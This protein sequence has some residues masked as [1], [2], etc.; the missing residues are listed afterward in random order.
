MKYPITI[1]IP[2]T[3][4]RGATI[5]FKAAP[6]ENPMQN[7]I[8]AKRNATQRLMPRQAEKGHAANDIPPT[9]GIARTSAIGAT[10][11]KSKMHPKLMRALIYQGLLLSVNY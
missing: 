5:T 2:Q 4:T 6:N 7:S 8:N 11:K 1:G 9:H 3:T 10:I